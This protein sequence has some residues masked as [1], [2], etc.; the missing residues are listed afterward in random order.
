MTAELSSIDSLVALYR[1]ANVHGRILPNAIQAMRIELTYNS[2]AI[3]G[4][5]LTLRDTQLVIE[6]QSPPQSKSMR[7]I[8]EARNHDRAIRLIDS[9]AAENPKPVPLSVD[10]LLKIHAS[11]L[12]DVSPREV[13]RF[14]SDRV[15]I[16]G[17][18]YIPPGSHRFDVL[19]PAMLE[20]ANR[21]NVHPLLVAAELHYNLVAIHPFADGNG[22]TARLMMNYYLLQVGYPYVIISVT[23]RSEY[24]AALDEANA[25]RLDRFVRFIAHSARLSVERILG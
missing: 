10:H 23:D 12:E 9:W 15:L 19:I 22:R 20:L 3:E 21:G 5:T 25:G 1:E 18:A 11:V 6:G 16:S 17:T 8:Y 7:E 4:N 13:G 14:R 2:N 24:L